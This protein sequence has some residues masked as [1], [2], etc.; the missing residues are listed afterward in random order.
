[1]S[2]YYALAG[3]RLEREG[4]NKKKEGERE[5]S[6]AQ[7]NPYLLQARRKELRSNTTGMNDATRDKFLIVSEQDVR[8]SALTF[9]RQVEEEEDDEVEEKKK[10][11]TRSSIPFAVKMQLGVFFV[12]RYSLR[13]IT[14]TAANDFCVTGHGQQRRYD[15]LELAAREEQI[16]LGKADSHRKKT[17]NLIE[18]KELH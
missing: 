2:I 4:E 5:S 12:R 7:Q 9:N 18:E 14:C 16:D 13:R 11:G 17:S 3:W 8:R 15:E 6:V 1:M 10:E